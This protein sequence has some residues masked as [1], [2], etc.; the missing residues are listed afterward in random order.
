M[1]QLIKILEELKP[2][3]NFR[4]ESDLLEKG[5][6]DSISI[7]EMIP[8]IVQIVRNRGH[9]SQAASRP[10]C[11]DGRKDAGDA[12]ISFLNTRLKADSDA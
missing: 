8:M 2:G 5:L 11:R 7:I 6:L 9:R 3:V 1:E 12:P 10:A 4:E